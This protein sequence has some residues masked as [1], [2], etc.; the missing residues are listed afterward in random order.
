M[1]Y[2]RYRPAIERV[3]IPHIDRAW[4]D[5]RLMTAPLWVP[6]D[7]RDGNQALS[8]PMDPDRKSALFSLLV[9]MGFKEIEIGYPSASQADFDFARRLCL[10]PSIPD[11]VTI[12]AF[13]PARPDLIDR[14]FEAMAGASKALIHLCAPTAPTW[15]SVVLGATR[16]EVLDMILRAG[17]Q[18]LRGADAEAPSLR[19]E[20]SPEVFTLTEP[21]YVLEVCNALTELWDASDDR[22]VVHNLPSTMEIATPNLYADQIEYM[23]RNLARRD[24]VIL[25]VHPHNDR[26]TGVAAAELAVLAGA[27]RVEG[28]LFGNGERTGNVDLV[29][30]ALNA[31]SQGVDP[32]VD[33]SAIDQ[34]RHTFEYCTR[35][36]VHPRHPYAGDLVYTAFSGTHQDA[37]RKGFARTQVEPYWDVPYLPIDPGDVGRTYEAVIRVNSQSGKGGVAYLLESCRGIRLPRAVQVEFAAVVQRATDASGRELSGD[38]LWDMFVRQYVRDDQMGIREVQEE[39]H[40]NECVITAELHM[41]GSPVRLSGRG[42]DLAAAAMDLLNGR[43]LDITALSYDMQKGLLP[44]GPRYVCLVEGGSA[45]A[46]RWGAGLG[47]SRAEAILQ[48]LVSSRARSAA[49]ASALGRS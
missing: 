39:Q 48:A 2:H 6:V 12:S 35:L 5:R 11:D 17:E 23:H 32:M 36:P 31:F 15:R 8:E 10:D 30:L 26:G 45:D 37:I 40:A 25:S 1:N 28:C 41:G 38:E 47:E 18:V 33:L 16:A 34:V 46:I 22:P 49:V 3:E 19:F 42:E 7:L 4:P 14:T 43:G 13:T 29:T 20:F 9:D 44:A 24:Q 27:Q 21:D